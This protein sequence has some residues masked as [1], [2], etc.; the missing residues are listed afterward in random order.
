MIVELL[1]VFL[2]VAG[3]AEGLLVWLSQ[4]LH[5]KPIVG[6][7]VVSIVVVLLL[8]GWTLFWVKGCSRDESSNLEWT[9]SELLDIFRGVGV[10][11][12]GVSV[13]V[14]G[15]A[16]AATILWHSGGRR[17]RV[18]AV[19]AMLPSFMLLVL[20]LWAMFFAVITWATQ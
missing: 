9:W 8:T 2:I 20:V 13:V 4:R 14:G 19:L 10:P 11:L 3:G 6:V 1:P 15:L 12:M 5:A 7:L 17:S 16:Y 18:Y